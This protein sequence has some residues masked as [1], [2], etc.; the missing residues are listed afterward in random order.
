MEQLTLCKPIKK[1][2]KEII[3]RF[4]KTNFDESWSF[5]DCTTKDTKY[6]THGYHRYPAKFIPQ[7]AR[8]LIENYT[9]KDDLVVDPFMGSGTTLVEAKILGRPSKGVDINDVAYLIAKT[10]V[11]P[12]EP[13][14][15]E[16]ESEDLFLKINNK[17][18][19]QNTHVDTSISQVADQNRIDY[20][21]NQDTKN[22][23]VINE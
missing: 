6:I 11:T 19:K 16:N 8:R 3:E 22:K 21:F 7:L 15:L 10:K 14:R 23:L 13:K 4:N 2:D 17:Y 1:F 12:I 18:N 5:E 20:W 9:D